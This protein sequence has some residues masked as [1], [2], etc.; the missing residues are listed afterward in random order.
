MLTAYSTRENTEKIRGI[1]G[2]CININGK[3]KVG[4]L[5]VMVAREAELELIAP[6]LIASKYGWSYEFEGATRD[7][8]CEEGKVKSYG[9]EGW[10]MT[11]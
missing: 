11:D 3:G 5:E 4:D 6:H 7:P 8:T 2:Q 10:A 9:R 1:G